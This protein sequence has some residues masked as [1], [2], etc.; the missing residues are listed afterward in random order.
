LNRKSDLT[1]EH[2]C[3]L[4]W[5]PTVKPHRKMMTRGQK[6]NQITKK[7]KNEKR[8]ANANIIVIEKQKLVEEEA[9]NPFE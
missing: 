3:P 2:G 5:L 1:D 9:V 6:L 8:N 4:E 7:G